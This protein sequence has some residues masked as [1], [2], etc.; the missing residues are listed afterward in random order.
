[1]VDKVRETQARN[2]ILQDV[3]IG[4]NGDWFL[5]TNKRNCMCSSGRMFG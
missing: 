1:L 3:A 5:K 4:P 2:E